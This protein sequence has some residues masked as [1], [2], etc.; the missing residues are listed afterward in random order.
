MTTSGLRSMQN[1][2]HCSGSERRVALRV[3]QTP[4][5]RSAGTSHPAASRDSWVALTN[6]TVRILVDDAIRN[7]V[8]HLRLTPARAG[9]RGSPSLNFFTARG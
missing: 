4:K 2:L 5:L 3:S 9:V 7:P 6:W 8:E 1:S